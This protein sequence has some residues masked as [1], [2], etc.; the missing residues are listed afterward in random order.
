MPIPIKDNIL[1]LDAMSGSSGSYALLGIRPKHEGGVVR[2][3]R[4]AGA[5]LL[6]KANLSE[7]CNVRGKVS[8][9]GWS[10]RGGQCEGAYYPK[11]CPSGSSSGCAVATDLALCFASIGSEV[12]T[13]SF[14]LIIARSFT[15]RHRQKGVSLLQLKLITSSVSNPPSALSPRIQSYQCRRSTTHS[16]LWLEQLKMLPQC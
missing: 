11:M 15:N 5:I 8:N 10:P 13:L 1:T 3:L 4:A 2:K 16:V 7:F 14:Y 6:G 12:G 9:S